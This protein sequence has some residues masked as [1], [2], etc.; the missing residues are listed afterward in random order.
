MTPQGLRGPIW[1]AFAALTL[2]SSGM[3]LEAQQAVRTAALRAPAGGDAITFTRDV[4]PIL[5][6]KCQVCHQPGSIAPMSLMTYE[7]VKPFSALIKQRVEQRIMPPWHIDKQ[8][9]I[10]DFKNDRSLSDEQIATIAAW[11][12]AG[13]PRGNPADMP[14]PVQWPDA[15]R[16]A[17]E[18]DLGPPDLVIRSSPYSVPTHGQDVW[19]RP[20]VETGLTEA[21]WLRAIAV[22]PS[23]PGGRKVVHHTL[24]TL[25]QEEK[26]ITGLASTAAESVRNPGLLT[27]WAIGKVGERY[28]D[29]TGKLMLPGSKIRFEVHYSTMAGVAVPDDQ[30]EVGLWFYPKDYTPKYRTILRI[31]NVSNAGTLE[32]PPHSFT[33][34]QNTFVLSAPARLESFQPHMHM[35]G[36]GLAMEAI[37][38]DGRREVLSM[39]R[40]FQWKWH[41]NYIYADHVAPL[42]PKGTVLQF[43]VWHDNTAQN[44]SNPDPDQYITWGDR[45]VDEMGHA[46]VGVTY[47]EQ[48]DFERLVAERKKKVAE[49]EEEHRHR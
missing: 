10:Q 16:F 11:V 4:A 49:Q 19:W 1:C 8:I 7:E 27:E 21:R 29:N 9:G 45:T 15:T 44:P 20:V 39:V 23:Y 3:T 38:P 37:Y 43:T 14:P 40:N 34:H 22:K 48:E 35:R 24:V 25:L 18:K 5:Q 36:R 30:V 47:L 26:G 6:Q 12:D 42:L 31:F 28:P 13:M 17:F 32:I 2:L 46:W 33:T 41:N